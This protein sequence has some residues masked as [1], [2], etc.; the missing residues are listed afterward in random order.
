[1]SDGARDG[2]PPF[3]AQSEI[4]K[5]A[6]L[7]ERQPQS[8][9]YLTELPTA[10][11]RRLREQ[12][13]DVLFDANHKTLTRLA[14]ASKLLPATLTAAI[15]QRAFGPLLAARIA[16]LLEPARAVEVAAKLPPKFLA[17]VAVELDPRRASDVIARIP[18][19]QIKAVAAELVL[20]H[21]YVAMGRFVGH[22]PEQSVRASLEVI[23]DADLLRL[24]FVLEQK[25]SLGS[26]VGLL[27]EKRLDGLI[28]AAAEHD[29]WAEALDLLNHLDKRRRRKL[30]E[31]AVDKGPPVLEP[32]VVT[33]ERRDM[34][35]EVLALESAIGD[36]SRDRF[37]GFIEERHPE[38]QEKL[39]LRRGA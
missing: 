35:D 28:D 10:D 15:A 38:L 33:A 26:L 27:S 2:S 32:L 24:G 12:V 39:E 25:E 34:W 14:A 1:M 19:A 4:L 7:L 31:R 17:D 5:L 37:I 13:T 16:G 3:E 36:A 20:R 22:L 8:L 6:R 30:V 29:L 9:E 11:L 18:P 23:D 21:E